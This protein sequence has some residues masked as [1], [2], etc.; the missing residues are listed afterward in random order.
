MADLQQFSPDEKDA[1]SEAFKLQDHPDPSVSGDAKAVITKYQQMTAPP[2]Y[3]SD[4]TLIQPSHEPLDLDTPIVSNLKKAGKAVAGFGSGVAEMVNPL[5][6]PHGLET[7]AK[8]PFQ[9]GSVLEKLNK[10]EES[11]HIFEKGDISQISALA[12]TAVKGLYGTIMGDKTPIGDI[13]DREVL[14]EQS[15]NA[16][17]IYSP[18]KK[19][20]EAT[21]GLISLAGLAKD[22]IQLAPKL[23]E[24][25]QSAANSAAYSALKPLGK[26]VDKVAGQ[27]RVD[28]IG[29][30]LLKDKIITSGASFK[31]ILSRT[32]AKLKDYG[33]EIGYFAKTA[34][35]AREGDSSIRGIPLAQLKSDIS[36]KVIQP[37]LEDP[38]TEGIAKEVS[39][40]TN[41]LKASEK[42][43]DELSFQ[44]AQKMKGTLDQLKAKF[45][46]AN[47]TLSKDAFQQVYG[48]LN[49]HMES[50]INNALK[51]AAPE[52]KN[53]FKE[54]K[55]AYRNLSDAEE[56][57]AHTVASQNK[58]RF[59]S[60]SD[61][62]AA[63]TAAT[64]GAVHST[65]ATIAL[66]VGGAAANKLLRSY[67]N[68]AQA[69]F[70]NSIAKNP[71][72]IKVARDI[73]GSI[74]ASKVAQ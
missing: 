15:G 71:N 13:Y 23:P 74:N 3:T 22:A 53:G 19:V 36:S 33:E 35:K 29:E 56:A 43:G 55:T 32:E 67:G 7:L 12:N 21:T 68:Q 37:L 38:S 5:S 41:K 50:G 25:V 14:K 31:D 73:I 62:I 20:G 48:I 57:I 59:F 18:A 65:P 8:T 51:T 49:S 44:Q 26:M 39:D 61:Y 11:P 30:Q 4:Q 27:N 58:N 69:S 28:A 10:A 9:E 60:L 1:I 42:T 46:T 64:A 24:A 16:D 52:I 34:D 72:E 2:H 17:P 70:F 45:G 6:A 54:A 40:W 47:D 66:G 63:T